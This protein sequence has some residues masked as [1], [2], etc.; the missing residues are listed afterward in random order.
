MT[1][2]DNKDFQWFDKKILLH[3]WCSSHYSIYEKFF[4]SLDFHYV[5]LV[6]PFV[7]TVT[8]CLLSKNGKVD[9]Y[10]DWI[11][12]SHWHVF[13]QYIRNLNTTRKGPFTLTLLCVCEILFFCTDVVL[14]ASHSKSLK[15]FLWKMPSILK[16]LFRTPV[17]SKKISNQ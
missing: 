2:T 12:N 1:V 15:R 17:T 14:H 7:L 4:I 11:L 9:L 10:S 8:A 6:K 3:L 5:K 13:D 16:S